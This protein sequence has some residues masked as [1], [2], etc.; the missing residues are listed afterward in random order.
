MTKIYILSL[1]LS[2]FITDLIGQ[3][4]PKQIVVEQFSNT[5][6]SICASRIPQLRQNMAP[7][8][9]NIQLI[10]FYSAAPYPNC[11]LYQANTTGNNARVT[12]YNVDGSPRV[13]V[14]GTL[15]NSGSGLVPSAYF[16]ERINE[17]SDVE[18]VTTLNKEALT[19]S[20][21]VTF[22][23]E[24]P[25]GELVINTYLTEK[26]VVAGQLAGFTEHHNVFREHLTASSGA[27]ITISQIGG[28]QTFNFNIGNE[29]VNKIDDILIVSVVQN[30]ATKE[31][32]N[33]G[34]SG[35]TATSVKGQVT[36]NVEIFPN[37]V[38][39]FLIL[40]IEPS[41]CENQKVTIFNESGRILRK[42]NEE[43][44]QHGRIDLSGLSSGNYVLQG[45]SADCRWSKKFVVIR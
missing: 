30:R 23:N 31:I 45:V 37:P 11:E 6:C 19:A 22:H 34:D 16:A 25:E 41:E 2:L 43:E 33:A 13:Y 24:I 21:T 12:Y 29:W 5:R 20:A 9:E 15:V 26:R 36:A 40:K 38:T 8:Q 1:L 10:S 32:F 44:W 7:Y 27:A 14:N 4:V 39:D 17:M 35:K 18:V 28:S 3:K 42:I